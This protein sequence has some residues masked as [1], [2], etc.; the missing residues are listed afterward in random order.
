L[1]ITLGASRFVDVF[2]P[3]Q[4]RPLLKLS[5]ETIERCQKTQ[6]A[7]LRSLRRDRYWLRESSGSNGSWSQS[8]YGTELAL[9]MGDISRFRTIKQAITRREGLLLFCKPWFNI[10]SRTSLYPDAR[11]SSFYQQLKNM[12]CAPSFRF[13]TKLCAEAIRDRAIAARCPA[14]YREIEPGLH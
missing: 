9:E 7:L 10:R 4:V 14:G 2:D 8:D 1:R 11:E 13:L 3:T 5:R 6:Y 12:F